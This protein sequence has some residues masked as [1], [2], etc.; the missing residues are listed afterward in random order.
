MENIQKDGQE[1]IES[2]TPEAIE[3]EKEQLKESSEDEIRASVIEKYGLDE[4]EQSDLVESLVKDKLEEKKKLTTAIGQ[5]IKYREQL[6]SKKEEKPEEKPQLQ[7]KVV[8][9]EDEILK[10]VEERLN[11]KELDS[12]GLSD[13]LKQEVQNYAKLRNVSITEAV[14]SPF[15]QFQIK[16]AEEKAKAEEASISS[17]HKTMAKRDFSNMSPK[18]FD[19][20]TPEGRKEFEEYDKWLRSQ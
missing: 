19:L 1:P 15:I 5:K 4:L 6:Q 9:S 8:L 11:Q 20:S 12:L 10:K 3:A 17:T 13:E 18:D 7:P 14:K 16:E 2:L